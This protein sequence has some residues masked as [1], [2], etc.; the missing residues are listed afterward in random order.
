VEEQGGVNRLTALGKQLARLP[1][2]PR[3]G[4]MI[5]AGRDNAC[6]TE[7]LIIAAAVSV[8][9]PRD[10]PMDAQNAADNA[11]KKFADEKS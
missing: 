7:L 8:Q 6:L 3:V 2:D 9:D 1:L 5:L 10:R 11:H 4:R